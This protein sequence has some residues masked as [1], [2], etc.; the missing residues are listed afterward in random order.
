MLTNLSI[1]F[2]IKV[3]LFL[4]YIFQASTSKPTYSETHEAVISHGTII[5]ENSVIKGYHAFKIKPPDTDPKTKLRIDREYT[6][7][8]DKDA[9]LVWIPELSD[10]DGN[11][12]NMVTDKERNLILSDIAGLPIGHVPRILASCFYE[13]LDNGGTVYATATGEPVPSFPPW[14]APQEK[15]GGVVIPCSYTLLVDNLDVTV[16]MLSETLSKMKEGNVMKI[17]IHND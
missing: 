13:V 5:L 11:L 16:K 1:V 4:C 12:H 15:G 6:N 10:L 9:C 17:N 7:I 14:P 2:A 3:F 8:S